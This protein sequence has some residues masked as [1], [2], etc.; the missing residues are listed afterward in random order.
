[1]KP[2]S[3]RASAW[4]MVVLR[5][6][7]AHTGS[8]RAARRACHSALAAGAAARAWQHGGPALCQAACMCSVW[9]PALRRTA[10]LLAR[11]RMCLVISVTRLSLH[12]TAQ[13]RGGRGG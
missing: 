8:R 6:Q 1:V 13:R 5:T 4:A 7:Q 2:A 10:L 12:V 3:S 9:L 11:T